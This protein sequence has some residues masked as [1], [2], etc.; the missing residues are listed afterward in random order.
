[1]ISRRVHRKKSIDTTHGD[2][3]FFR[4][5]SHLDMIRLPGTSFL[6]LAEAHGVLTR[7][8]KGRTVGIAGENAADRDEDPANG[9]ADSCVGPIA[10]SEHTGITVDI[11]LLTN[12]AIHEK[13]RT[14]ITGGCLN[15]V[16]G[17]ARLAHT[18]A[19]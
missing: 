17:E 6:V 19:H 4:L 14:D 7:P 5:E 2:R 12:G 13:R 15:P 11:E 3:T 18:P 10:R 1:P 16:E 8:A 9:P